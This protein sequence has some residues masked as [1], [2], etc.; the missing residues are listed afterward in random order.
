MFG[1]AKSNLGMQIQ[2]CCNPELFQVG[3]F[4]C[5]VL[6]QDTVKN[7]LCPKEISKCKPRLLQK[8]FRSQRGSYQLIC[9]S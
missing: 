3:T 6:F 7:M 8:A 2:H 1:F 4:S 9:V 5:C